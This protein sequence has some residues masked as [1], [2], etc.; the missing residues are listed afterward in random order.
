MTQDELDRVLE[1]ALDV[2]PA[3]GYLTRV[4]AR[5][6][7]EQVASARVQAWWPLGALAAAVLVLVASGLGV[8]RDGSPARVA[9]MTSP[10]NNIA[11][12]DRVETASAPP[13]A[14]AG[15]TGRTIPGRRQRGA[16]ATSTARTERSLPPADAFPTVIVSPDDA[17][18]LRLLATFIEPDLTAQGTGGGERQATQISRIDVAPIEVDLLPDLP[19]LALGELQ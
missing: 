9:T 7:A 1:E 19:P 4:R 13:V 6:A 17:A 5:I 2:E 10:A 18:G 11:G 8:Q 14:P 12:E 3:A 15:E 16:I